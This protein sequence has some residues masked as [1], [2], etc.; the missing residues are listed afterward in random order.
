[1][2]SSRPRLDYEK[3]VSCQPTTEAA[4]GEHTGAATFQLKLRNF[5]Q[6]ICEYY[7]VVMIHEHYG[8][9]HV[10]YERT[11]IAVPRKHAATSSRKSLS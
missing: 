9:C 6:A 10:S 4:E 2:L 11:Q 7:C 3:K 1:M 5:L 8:S